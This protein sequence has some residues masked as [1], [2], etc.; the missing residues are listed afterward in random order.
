[1]AGWHKGLD[2]SYVE[3]SMLKYR[4]MRIRSL[5][6]KRWSTE[7]KTVGSIPAGFDHFYTGVLL[8]K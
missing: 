7:P 4:I 5:M 6:E 1:M 8:H 3:Y 2:L